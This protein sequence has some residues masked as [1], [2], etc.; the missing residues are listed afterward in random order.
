MFFCCFQLRVTRIVKMVELVM[1][2]TSVI[3]QRVMTVTLTAKN[4]SES[5]QFFFKALV[6]GTQLVNLLYFL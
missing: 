4:V 6:I 3:V 5:Q 2:Q 1:R